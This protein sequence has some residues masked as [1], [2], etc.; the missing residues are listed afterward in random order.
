MK[1]LSAILLFVLSFC[2]PAFAYEFDVKA[3]PTGPDTTHVTVTE[4]IRLGSDQFGDPVYISNPTNQSDDTGNEEAAA[5][6]AE[7]AKEHPVIAT[8]G[9]IAFLVFML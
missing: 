4:R 9:A 6:I 7:F 8:I 5:A 3:T 1:K 2:F